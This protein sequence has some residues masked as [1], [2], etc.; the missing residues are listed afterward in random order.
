[1]FLNYNSLLLNFRWGLIINWSWRSWNS[2]RWFFISIID[3][4]RRW[5]SRCCCRSWSRWLFIGIIDDLS[6]W[7]GG[8]W[9]F[10]I[11]IVN[12]FIFLLNRN[13]FLSCYFFYNCSHTL[14][15]NGKNFSLS[16]TWVTEDWIC[17]LNRTTLF[18]K[19]FFLDNSKWTRSMTSSDGW[20]FS[21]NTGIWKSIWSKQKFSNGITGSTINFNSFPF[22]YFS[23]SYISIYIFGLLSL[24]NNSFIFN[25][26]WGLIVIWSCGWGSCSWWLFISIIDDL[27]SW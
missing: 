6:S 2:R 5:W 18:V 11:G 15:L 16:M 7:W 25:L 27:S 26:S 22:T 3:D 9:W 20:I 4:F 8:S 17:S 10:F 1:L 24:Y 19:T 23:T 14:I 12:Y 21:T 13:F